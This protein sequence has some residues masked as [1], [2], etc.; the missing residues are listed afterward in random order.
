MVDMLSLVY[1]DTLDEKI[2]QTLSERMQDVYDI[3]GSLPD[4]DYFRGRDKR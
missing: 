4:M 1:H 3:F 2:Y